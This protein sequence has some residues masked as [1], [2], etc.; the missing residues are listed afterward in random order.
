MDDLTRIFCERYAE[1]VAIMENDGGN[2]NAE[3]DAINDIIQS[4]SRQMPQYTKF[5]TSVEL[6]ETAKQYLRTPDI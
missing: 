6:R 5:F 1:R 2:K 4:L 3:Q